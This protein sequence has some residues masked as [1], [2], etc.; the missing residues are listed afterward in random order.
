MSRTAWIA[1]IVIVVVA[2]ALGLQAQ[3]LR[4]PTADS[5][6]IT[7][8]HLLSHASGLPEDN[9]SADLRM[10]MTEADFDEL[11]SHGL[12][13]TDDENP[14]STASKRR[15]KTPRASR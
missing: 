12:T 14:T 15:P 8:R 13:T 5:P 9:A 1:A 2:P 11:L 3:W 7:V 10:P 4:Y 6:R